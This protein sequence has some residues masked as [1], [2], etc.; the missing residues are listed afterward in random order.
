MKVAPPLPTFFSLFF[1]GSCLMGHGPRQTTH[2]TIVNFGRIQKRAKRTRPLC[3]TAWRSNCARRTRSPNAS[4]S[5]TR[6]INTNSVIIYLNKPRI[7]W[8]SICS[9]NELFYSSPML[10]TRPFHSGVCIFVFNSLE[11]GTHVF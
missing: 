2:F 9:S 10:R 4:R 5:K 7:R 3:S 8:R 1:F 11:K 6:H